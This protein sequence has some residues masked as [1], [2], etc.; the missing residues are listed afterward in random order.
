MALRKASQPTQA[1]DTKEGDTKTS[2][3]SVETLDYI[4]MPTTTIG[5]LVSKTNGTSTPS[6]KIQKASNKKSD[7]K[8][9][10]RYDLSEEKV[11]LNARNEKLLNV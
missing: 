7:V 9:A 1:L 4:V 10:M 11:F 3:L 5:A 2:F 8:A 6:F